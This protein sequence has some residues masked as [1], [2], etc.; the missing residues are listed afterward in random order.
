MPRT[1]ENIYKRKDGRWEGRYIKERTGSKTSYGYVYGKS[2]KEVKIRLIQL[3]AEWEKKR[4]EE[5]T[6]ME[7]DKFSNIASVWLA[8][9]KPLFKESTLVKYK[10]LLRLYILPSIGDDWISE[11]TDEKIHVLCSD[12]LNTGGAK[13]T[14]LSP[15]T[16]T[17]VLSLLRSIQKY[18]LSRNMK[19]TP[20]S[21]S[22]PIKHSQKQLRVLSFQEHKLLYN[23]LKSNLTLSNL[24]IILC[25]FTGIRIGELCALKWSDISITEKTLYVHQTMQRLHAEGSNPAKT[26]ILLSAPKSPCSIRLIPLPTHL[27]EWI[28]PMQKHPDSFFL[29]GDTEKFIEPRRMQ[30]HFKRVLKTCDIPDANFHVLRHTFATRCIESGFDL[31][32]LSEILGHSNVNITL[33]RYVHPTLE[34]KRENMS[35]MFEQFSVT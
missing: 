26:Q 2:Y 7:D 29:T 6:L 34:L 21:C 28:L 31:K 17:D 3:K 22:C 13:K 12:L 14:G 23:Y 30:Y 35:K 24:G 5:K 4:A 15:K 16:V 19:A 27:M 1:G 33:N 18:A 25:L 9:S 8:I 20:I 32:S 11:I 10:N